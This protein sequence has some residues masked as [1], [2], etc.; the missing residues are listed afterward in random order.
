MKPP[1]LLTTVRGT[2]APGPNMIFRPSSSCTNTNVKNLHKYNFQLVANPH[3]QHGLGRQ[4]SH[5][6]LHP[7]LVET[8]APLRDRDVQA[9]IHLKINIE[10]FRRPYT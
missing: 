4:V 2:G 8:L 10:M 1:S 5:H 6:P 7:A 3:L 9:V